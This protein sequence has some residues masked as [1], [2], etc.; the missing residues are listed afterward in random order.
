MN[1]EPD[2]ILI[3]YFSGEI[4][5]EERHALE[6]WL[7]S[8]PDNH[9]ALERLR[10]LWEAS[11]DIPYTPDT[12]SALKALKER[13]VLRAAGPIDLDVERVRGSGARRASVTGTRSRIPRTLRI[14]AMIAAVLG[15]GVVVQQM[16][17][18]P[19]SD[20]GE[21]TDPRVVATGP[22]Q[23]RTLVLGDGTTVMLSVASR[24]EVPAEYGRS[25]RNLYLIGEAYF[26]VTHDAGRPFR[27]RTSRGIAEDLGTRFNVRAYPETAALEVVVA[28]GSVALSRTPPARPEEGDP[29]AE[30]RA[31]AVIEAGD[32]GR[33]EADG[34][35]LVEHDVDLA[36]RLAWIERRLAFDQMPLREVLAQLGRW[37]DLDTQVTDSTL[38][39][40]PVTVSFDN[41]ALSEVL[42]LLASAVGARY[43]RSGRKV[44]FSRA[45]R[46]R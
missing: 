32:L 7:A 21:T 35:V 45:P 18:Q 11:T 44:T 3:R 16:I 36:T 5:A 39:S 14:A 41:E 40:Q 27:V 13:A 15:G 19:R 20:T 23:L 43:E 42:E 26:D 9:G 29:A 38:A 22:G 1:S 12:E 33:L 4:S 17:L 30:T 37:Y 10:E 2:T 34:M 46:A 31:A 24:L 28:E 6:A 25:A 8:D